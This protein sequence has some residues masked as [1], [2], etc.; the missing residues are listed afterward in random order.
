MHA[1]KQITPEVLIVLIIGIVA[2]MVIYR[3]IFRK[4]NR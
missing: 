4:K 2:Y 1:V 3:A